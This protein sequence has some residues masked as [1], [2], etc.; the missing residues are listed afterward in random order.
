MKALH[1]KTGMNADYCRMCLERNNW[2]LDASYANFVDL[3][4]MV[5]FHCCCCSLSSACLSH[6]IVLA[7]RVNCQGKLS[8]DAPLVFSPLLTCQN[9]GTCQV[10]NKRNTSSS[11]MIHVFI[12]FPACITRFFISSFITHIHIVPAAQCLRLRFF[13]GGEPEEDEDDEESESLD[14]ESESESESDEESDDDSDSDSAMICFG[15]FF[16]C[17]LRSS[18][19]GKKKKR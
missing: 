18:L 12:L 6:K 9:K 7:N 11:H 1:D 13:G 4:R 10:I 3:Q 5:L 19:C 8:H 14:D 2:A 16:K 17:S 15:A